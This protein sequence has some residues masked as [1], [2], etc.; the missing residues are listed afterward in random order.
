MLL[1]RI[2]TV[3]YLKYCVVLFVLVFTFGFITSDLPARTKA[4][5]FPPESVTCQPVR[6]LA[7]SWQTASLSSASTW[8]GQIC[9]AAPGYRWE[10]FETVKTRNLKPRFKS[11]RRYGPLRGPTSSSCGVIRPSAEGFFCPSCKKRTYYAVLANFRPFWM[12]SSG[13]LCLLKVLQFSI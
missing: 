5:Q 9:W 2:K 8:P 3:R 11:T 12:Y 4:R 7:R 13:G 6:I 1:P 10:A